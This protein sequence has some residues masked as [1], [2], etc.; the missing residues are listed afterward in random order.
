MIRPSF[1]SATLNRVRQPDRSDGAALP[2]VAETRSDPKLRS[3]FCQPVC[4]SKAK[5]LRAAF[6]VLADV[7]RKRP[8]QMAFGYDLL[9]CAR[10]KIVAWRIE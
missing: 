1:R 10:R 5:L 8:F 6:V 2:G 3:E 4:T 9:I 7:P